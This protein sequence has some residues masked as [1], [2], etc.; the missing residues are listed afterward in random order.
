[1]A[2]FMYV[3]PNDAKEIAHIFLARHIDNSC[4][5]RPQNKFKGL[6]WVNRI[7]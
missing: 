1:M 2:N 3:N 7:K 4:R 6:L 5:T